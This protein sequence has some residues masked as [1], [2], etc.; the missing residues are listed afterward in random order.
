M[1]EKELTKYD[2]T[3]FYVNEIQP[4]IIEIKSKR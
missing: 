4:A 3:D 1:E 2:L